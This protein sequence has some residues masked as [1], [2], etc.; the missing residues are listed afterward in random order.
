MVFQGRRAGQSLCVRIAVILIQREEKT[1]TSFSS[2]SFGYALEI[3][4]NSNVTASDILSAVQPVSSL[5]WLALILLLDQIP[6][7]CYRDLQSSIVF[8]YFDPLALD[9]SL[10]AREAGVLEDPQVRYQF[11]YRTWFLLPMM[12]SEQ[13]EMHAI[14]VREFQRLS[15]DVEELLVDPTEKFAIDPRKLKCRSV[16]TRKKEAARALCAIH[17]EFEIRHQKIIERFGRYPHRN[18]TLG[19][20]STEEE[21]QYLEGGGETFG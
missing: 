7:N 3:I 16:L 10:R 15:D 12:H 6:R 5:D 14:A 2:A 13:I 20:L 21:K 19:R 4:H 8:A 1:L 17:L 11:A 9:I 18:E